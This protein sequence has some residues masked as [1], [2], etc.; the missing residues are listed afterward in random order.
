M[1]HNGMPYDLIQG[2]G[3]RGQ[4]VVKMANFKVYLISGMHEMK[5]LMVN[6]DNPRQCLNL[7]I[8]IFHIHPRSVSHDFQ[9]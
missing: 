2:Q 7:S 9:S 8:Q 4:K 1:I 6:Y 5:R 3:H